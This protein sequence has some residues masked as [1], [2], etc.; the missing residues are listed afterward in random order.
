MLS[1]PFSACV[2][3]ASP[4]TGNQGV[5]ALCWSTLDGMTR[6]GCNDLRVFGFS[7]GKRSAHYGGLNYT[8]YGM[9]VGK[10]LWRRNHLGRANLSATL[11]VRKNILL[12]AMADSD[13]ILDVSGGDSFT[14]LYGNARFHNII[15][16][17]QLSLKLQR[18]LVLLPQTYGPFRYERNRKLARTLVKGAAAAFA[19]DAE[20]FKSLKSLL[21]DVF[22]TNLHKQG[23]DMAFGL[24]PRKPSVLGSGVDEALTLKGK[25][26][27][28]GLNVS[29]LIANQQRHAAKQFGLKANY[30][31]LIAALVKRLLNTTDAHLLIIPHVHAPIGHYE[32]DL[33]AS[34]HLI[35]QLP[36]TYAAVAKKRITVSEN[37]LDAC[38]LK[39]L[40]AQCDWFCGT[41][42]HAT[43]AALSSGVPATALAYSLKTRGVFATCQMGDA[44]I[45]LRHES[46]ETALEKTMAL[47][48]KRDVHAAHLNQQLPHVKCLASRQMDF[49]VASMGEKNT[50]PRADM[51]AI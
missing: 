46:S 20:S 23:V 19:R 17:K 28:I 27:I 47:W 6:R 14:D 40:I 13:L 38:E 51:S 39:W 7:D 16:P 4:D 45:D 44:C 32:S 10:R 15:A 42:M 3:G 34:R 5:N 11:G 35:E 33:Q 29:G 1:I 41:R 37:A 50:S 2:F 8:L 30:P 24:E 9:T 18:P 36:W 22:D 12:H 26:P 49:I 21:G 43:I 25:R 48:E 31:K